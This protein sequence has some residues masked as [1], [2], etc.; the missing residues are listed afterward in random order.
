MGG[1]RALV[2][3]AT[4]FVG[5]ALV[6]AL[7]RAGVEV[8][9]TS[10]KPRAPE[11]AVSW[12][13]CD[14]SSREGLGR[15]LEGI[16]VAYFLV[17]GMGGGAANYAAHEAETARTFAEV[18]QARGV[19][20][21]V[22]LGGVA[23]AREPS[24]HLQSRLTVGEVLR[25]GGVPTL[26]LRASMIVGA[27]SASWKM[28][29]DLALRLPAM[30]LPRWTRSATCPVAID[31]VVTAL[32]A[33]KDAPLPKSEW[34]DLPGPEVMTGA[35]VLSRLAALEGRVVPAL[36]VP[37]LSPSLSSWWLKLVTGADFSLARELVLGF[38]SDL[39]PRD[40]R[41]W[42]LIGAP[43]RVPFDEAARRARADEYTP[44]SLS[45]VLAD[46]LESGVRLVGQRL[47]SARRPG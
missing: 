12:V 30:V 4:G 38:T 22:Y 35:E 27:G 32:V 9:A 15:A 33:A 46:T 13:T 10:R 19:G 23:P 3:G 28:V 44:A 7:V 26:E 41:Y 8:R 5:R 21:I 17:H 16:D 43:P 39:L 24:V 37:L 40:D 25:A 20:R 36:P 18:A 42:A 45:G 11:A 14:V 34:F 1:M 2:T 47:A 6:P 29:R 31:D